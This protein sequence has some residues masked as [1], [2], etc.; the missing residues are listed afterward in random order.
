MDKEE[1]FDSY[2]S[3]EESE[4]RLCN[5]QA[6]DSPQACSPHSSFVIRWFPRPSRA[7]PSALG[8]AGL[9]AMAP[10]GMDFLG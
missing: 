3:P 10:A 2:L 8:S 9:D 5:A 6:A 7:P 4:R 1:Q